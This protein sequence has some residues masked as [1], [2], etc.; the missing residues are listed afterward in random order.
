MEELGV[1]D[2]RWLDYRDF[3]CADVDVD[4]ASERIAAIIDEVRPDTVLTFGPDGMTGHPDHRAVSQWTER[5][6]K[7]AVSTPTL[8]FATKT[9]EWASMF[10]AVGEALGVMM[11]A[12]E[13][14]RTPRDQLAIHVDL[15][16][17]LLD[18]KERAMLA[19]ASQVDDMIAA[20]G[21]DRYRDVLREES[22]RLP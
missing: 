5:A 4:E 17:Q 12:D 3:A 6:S 11:G 15:D 9:P 14:P 20:L 19:Q 1:T 21:R 16:G 8:Y 13:I 7:Q 18:I 2:H 22:F 10:E